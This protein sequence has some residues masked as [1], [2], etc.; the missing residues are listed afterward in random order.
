MIYFFMALAFVCASTNLYL[1]KQIKKRDFIIKGLIEDKI[2][3][4]ESRKE[5]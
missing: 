4:I 3:V 1:Y 2:Q 5:E